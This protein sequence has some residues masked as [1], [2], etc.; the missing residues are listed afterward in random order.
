MLVGQWQVIQA[1]EGILIVGQD[2]NPDVEITCQNWNS[3]T[4]PAFLFR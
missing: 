2:S 3:D 4:L 1:A